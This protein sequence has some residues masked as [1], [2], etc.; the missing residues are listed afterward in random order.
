MII[1]IKFP[2]IVVNALCFAINTVQCNLYI[3]KLI[4]VE[5]LLILDWA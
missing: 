5:I 3:F 2:I 4:A 1:P